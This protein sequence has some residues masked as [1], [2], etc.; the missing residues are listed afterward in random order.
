MHREKGKWGSDS[1]GLCFSCIIW[2][3][4]N[5][6]VFVHWSCVYIWSFKGVIRKYNEIHN[7]NW[8]KRRGR[9]TCH[10]QQE[11]SLGIYQPL[12]QW[13]DHFVWHRRKAWGEDLREQRITHFNGIR[14]NHLVK[15]KVTHHLLRATNHLLDL[16]LPTMQAKIN[17][18]SPEVIQPKSLL[19]H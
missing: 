3:F 14:F 17:L 5:K 13:R 16:N 1:E 10:L 15:L 7:L 9:A 2:I 4:Y 6:K 19:S 8:M 18:S 12:Q 11:N